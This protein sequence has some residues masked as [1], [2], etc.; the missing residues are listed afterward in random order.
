MG[1]LA[2][3]LLHSISI[4]SVLVRIHKGDQLFNVSLMRHEDSN[5]F[6]LLEQKEEDEK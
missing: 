1:L 3:I 2:S 4:A 6:T 5:R